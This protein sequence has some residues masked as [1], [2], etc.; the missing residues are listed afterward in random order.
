MTTPTGGIITSTSGGTVTGTGMTGDPIVVTVTGGGGTPGPP[1]PTG[2]AG[3][4]GAAGATGATGPA[5]PTGATGAAGATGATGPAGPTGATGA[6]GP[7]GATGATGPAG[8]TGATGPTGATGAN[9]HGSTV[10]TGTITTGATLYTVPVADST[11]FPIGSPTYVT[12]GTNTIRAIVGANSVGSIGLTIAGSSVSGSVGAVAVGAI[13]T[14]TG[15]AGGVGATGPTGPAGATGATGAAGATGPT[16]PTGPT[17]ATGAPGPAGAYPMFLRSSASCST[18]DP[19]TVQSSNSL[20]SST[21][22]LVAFT[23]AAS[24]TTTKIRY[25]VGTAA[26]SSGAGTGV[27]L[28]SLNA[29]DDGTLIASISNVSLF[30]GATGAFT[31]TWSASTT[32]TAGNRYAVAF[33]NVVNSGNPA[34]FSAVYPLTYDPEMF[35]TPFIF[36]TIGAQS[37]LPASFSH[38]SLGNNTSQRTPFYAVVL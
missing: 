25:Y 21:L 2:P 9:G 35:V 24:F 11:A 15:V 16:G 18:L 1:G 6:T 38:T 32:I 8:A 5:G 29:T 36:Q 26:T 23:A 33:L 17:G 4:T 20:S 27:G 22:Y 7:A 14:F 13:V 12:D 28:Y 10:T 30:T 37:S 31:Q 3:P 19:A 34:L